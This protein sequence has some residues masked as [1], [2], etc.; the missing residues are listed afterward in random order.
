VL[1]SFLIFLNLI[2]SINKSYIYINY[3]V[4]VKANLGNLIIN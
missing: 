3:A 4:D 1:L 2:Q